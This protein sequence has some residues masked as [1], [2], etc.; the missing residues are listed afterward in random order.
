MS[1]IKSELKN[2]FPYKFLEVYG[3]E[4]DDIIAVLCGELE[5][6]NGKTL[7][8]S[9]DKDFIQ[10]QKYKNVSQ[11]SPITKKFVNGADPTRYLIE[12]ILRG[13]TSDGIPNVLSPDHTFEQ[14]LRQRPLGKKKID[15]WVENGID[16]VLPNEEVKRNYQ[17]NKK[18]IDLD[19]SPTE[20][21]DT[22]LKEFREAPEGD[23]SKLLNYFMNKRLKD[24]TES[25]GEF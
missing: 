11:Y 24:L 18:L 25:I 13:D 4:A 3:A 23:R 10:L 15:T 16:D 20:L 8:V 7:I 17:R 9:G 6:D 5:F 21:F 1:E 14:G 2:I 12:H 22:I 19:Q